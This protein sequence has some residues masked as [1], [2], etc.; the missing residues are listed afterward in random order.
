MEAI[1]MGALSLNSYTLKRV[2]MH[3]IVAFARKSKGKGQK[4]EI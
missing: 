3:K 1:I 4:C 2:R